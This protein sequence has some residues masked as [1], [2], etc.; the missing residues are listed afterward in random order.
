VTP[1][2]PSAVVAPGMTGAAPGTAGPTGAT[3]PPQ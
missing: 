3:V 2:V 1:G